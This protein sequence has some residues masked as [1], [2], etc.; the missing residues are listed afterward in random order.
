TK[1]RDELLAVPAEDVKQHAEFLKQ[2]DSGLIKLLPRD[3]YGDEIAGMRGGGA[4]YAFVRKT[5]EYGYGSDVEL[6]NGR[7]TCGFAGADYGYFL[8]LGDVPIEDV[9]AATASPPK[10]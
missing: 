2:P 9:G 10:W 4:Y 5:H 6:Q 7:L 1:V 8:P 3:K